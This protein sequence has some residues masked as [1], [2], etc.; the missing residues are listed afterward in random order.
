MTSEATIIVEQNLLHQQ[1]VNLLENELKKMR[2]NNLT[3]PEA[4]LEE[5]VKKIAYCICNELF[6]PTQSDI[7]L[8]KSKEEENKKV[9]INQIKNNIVFPKADDPDDTILVMFHYFQNLIKEFSNNQI[10]KKDEGFEGLVKKLE[11]RFQKPEYAEYFK[12]K[13][14]A[15]AWYS[16]NQ[17]TN[18]KIDPNKIIQTQMYTDMFPDEFSTD[19]NILI[20]DLGRNGLDIDKNVIIEGGSQELIKEKG[21][22]HFY[23]EAI[24]DK[25]IALHFALNNCQKRLNQFPAGAINSAVI[26]LIDGEQDSEKKQKLNEL[27]NYINSKHS[28]VSIDKVDG[29]DNSYVYSC[30]VVHPDSNEEICY[31]SLCITHDKGGKTI[32]Y[33]NP[34]IRLGETLK[35]FGLSED[36]L[37]KSLEGKQKSYPA[38]KANEFNFDE[39]SPIDRINYIIYHRTSDKPYNKKCSAE[40]LKFLEEI[41]QEI[42]ECGTVDKES[43]EDIKS[44]K[45]LYLEISIS[46]IEDSDVKAEVAKRGGLIDF[47]PEDATYKTTKEREEL[48]NKLDE[49]FKRK[50]SITNEDC[51]I[52]KNDNSGIAGIEQDFSRGLKFNGWGLKEFDGNIEKFQAY[53]ESVKQKYPVLN[54]F[55][56]EYDQKYTYLTTEKI[57][58]ILSQYCPDSVIIGEDEGLSKDIQANE[59]SVNFVV[60]KDSLSFVYAGHFFCIPGCIQAIVENGKKTMKFSNTVLQELYKS[61]VNV[62]ITKKLDI[63]TLKILVERAKKEET[64]EY[65]FQWYKEQSKLFLDENFITKVGPYGLCKI[66]YPLLLENFYLEAKH[67]LANNPTM[68]AKFERDVEFSKNLDAVGDK[69]GAEKKIVLEIMGRLGGD[70][71]NGDLKADKLTGD[72][73]RFTKEN[74]QKFLDKLS[75]AA[76]KL[77]V[78]EKMFEII[79]TNDK[80]YK[81]YTHEGSFGIG[82]TTTQQTHIG[83]LQDLYVDI[84]KDVISNDKIENKEKREFLLKV[85]KQQD[86]NSL[87]NFN[88]SNG[89]DLIKTIMVKETK[90][91][92]DLNE[93]VNPFL[94]SN[95]GESYDKLPKQQDI[96]IKELN[97]Q[98]KSLND[99]NNVSVKEYEKGSDVEFLKNGESLTKNTPTDEILNELL[100]PNPNTNSAHDIFYVEIVK[101]VEKESGQQNNQKVLNAYQKIKNI[102]I[103]EIVDYI[104]EKPCVAHV[105]LKERFEESVRLS[106]PD[107]RDFRKEVEQQPDLMNKL[108]LAAEKSTSNGFKKAIQSMKEE[109]KQEKEFNILKEL[110][111][112]DPPNL[113][114]THDPFSLRHAWQ[115]Y[116]KIK[117]ISID[118]IVDFVLEHPNTAGIFF[119]K[120]HMGYAILAGRNFREEAAQKP[121]LLDKLLTAAKTS[122]DAEFVINIKSLFSSQHTSKNDQNSIAALKTQIQG[123]LTRI[124]DE[125]KL[126][127]EKKMTYLNALDKIQ[128]KEL[129]EALK[130]K[131]VILTSDD[132][133]ATPLPDINCMNTFVSRINNELDRNELTCEKYNSLCNETI[134]PAVD[135]S[136][137]NANFFEVMGTNVKFP[138]VG[139]KIE[140]PNS[141]AV[142]SV[143]V[144]LPPLEDEQIASHEALLFE[145]RICS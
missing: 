118:K 55:I 127:S 142:I 21:I 12:I 7:K 33:Q 88:C 22:L 131:F 70:G 128:N 120:R 84:V 136:S 103:E 37:K 6:D 56:S 113:Q 17:K 123:E 73:I 145:S 18:E 44:L 81:L 4:G 13:R 87:I 8:K 99:S 94:R 47:D 71:R 19:Y 115:A 133:R 129:R 9:D 77:N 68:Q 114:K 52:E 140:N 135:Q 141:K 90:A 31:A 107:Y 23:H 102:P 86:K 116:D 85:K 29:K 63:K 92:N 34:E 144:E 26:A 98:E 49:K 101:D 106:G 42:K 65:L 109:Q 48:Q 134:V 75:S 57:K 62:D 16:G 66:D 50:Y 105:F 112:G 61:E 32:I 132:I 15:N 38:A 43:I 108:S 82:L 83:I 36:K 100:R 2:E 5:L 45:A 51:R 76:E 24:D 91:S 41:F 10:D 3:L 1:V 117:D 119:Q 30:R 125:R 72:K 139:Y 69:I 78:L 121:E 74:I 122:S 39:L 97:S 58:E 79:K 96:V 137:K 104:L 54:E 95:L 40:K 35:N 11:E 110:I 60:E 20:V 46:D 80:Q 138:S 124:V 126:Y 28:K 53:F 25:D 111:F 130:I 27:T 93:V 143:K 64:S 14:I 89:P 67:F 59:N